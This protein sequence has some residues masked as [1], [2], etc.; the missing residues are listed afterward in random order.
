ML[1]RIAT[2]GGVGILTLALHHYSLSRPFAALVAVPT[3]GAKVHVLLRFCKPL[4]SGFISHA[5]DGVE[6]SAFAGDRNLDAVASGPDATTHRLSLTAAIGWSLGAS[7]FCS[8][9]KIA[10]RSTLGAEKGVFRRSGYTCA[11]LTLKCS[12]SR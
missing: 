9:A 10:I 5:L 12:I 2:P 4:L 6:R 3:L 1:E 11:A 7:R 8:L